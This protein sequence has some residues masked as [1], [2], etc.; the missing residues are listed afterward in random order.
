MKKTLWIQLIIF[1]LVGCSLQ[2]DHPKYSTKTNKEEYI[3]IATGGKYGPYFSIG[4]SMADIFSEELQV[5]ASVQTTGGSVENLLLLEQGKAEIAF[6]MSDV[7]LS[8]YLGKGS[9][10]K[11]YKNFRAIAGLYLNCV[12]IITLKSSGIQSVKDLKGK[13][14]GIG[15]ENSGVEVNARM[16]LKGHG[17]NEYD[18]EPFMLSYHEAMEQLKEGNIDAAFVTSGLPN[19]PVV[20]LSKTKELSV[21][22]IYLKDMTSGEFTSYFTSAEIPANMYGNYHSIQTI[23]I[24]NLLLVRNDLPEDFVFRLTSRLYKN[25]SILRDAHEA[26]QQVH[27]PVWIPELPIPLHKG[28]KQYYQQNQKLPID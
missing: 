11:E 6:V 18:Y 23:G 24:Q 19:G 17:L 3:T 22:P 14:I 15:A 21:V 7:A 13:K 10:N 5:S 20:E 4:S 12:Q 8:A 2:K 26:M 27:T 28:A 16:V 1:F 25:I 9:F